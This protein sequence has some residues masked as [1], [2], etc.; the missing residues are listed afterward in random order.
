[1]L[2]NSNKQNFNSPVFASKIIISKEAYLKVPRRKLFY[3]GK[4][5]GKP[6]TIKQSFY[7]DEGYSDSASVCTMGLIKPK[8]GQEGF[9]FHICPGQTSLWRIKR[10][11]T[12]VVKNFNKSYGNADNNLSGILVGGCSSEDS[13]G[14]TSTKFFKGLTKIFESLK[15][16]FTS[17]LGRIKPSDSKDF[18]AVDLYFSAKDDKIIIN[19]KGIEPIDSLV[20]LEKKFSVV[21]PSPNDTIVFE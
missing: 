19:P 11:L 10:E 16:D 7:A 12:D 1:M 6:W 18:K 2:I 3:Q 8:N 15:I 14:R 4:Y 5:A 20:E 21:K 17:V 9:L 13:Y